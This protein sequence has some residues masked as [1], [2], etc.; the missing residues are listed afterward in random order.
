[1]E[2]KDFLEHVALGKTIED[3]SEIHQY[4]VRENQESRKITMKMNNTYHDSKE[5][6]NLFSELIGKQVDESFGLFP[7]FYTDFGKNITL[8]KHVFINSGCSFQDQGG[9]VIGE[10]TL[11]GHNVMIATL[12]HDM[13]PSKR[14]DTI[15]RSVLIGK[16]VWIGSNATIL[17]GVTI[18]DYAIV[19]AGAIVSKDVPA[20]AVVGGVPAKIIKYIDKKN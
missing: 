2:L 4:M 17:P 9:I 16:K 13:T 3:R 20:Y 12:N 5:L 1:M 7:P 6:R 18:G 14:G 10:G 11:V 8:G 15:P 19:A